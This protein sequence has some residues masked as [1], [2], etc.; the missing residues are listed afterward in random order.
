VGEFFAV[1][2]GEDMLEMRIPKASVLPEP[3]EASPMR[4]WP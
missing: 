1:G 4:S 3:V 2:E